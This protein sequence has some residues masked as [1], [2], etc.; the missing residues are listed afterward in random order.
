MK[1]NASVS[2]N[3]TN[4]K[5]APSEVKTAS[6]ATPSSKIVST[7]KAATSP[8][9]KEHS[10]TR[11]SIAPS[12]LSNNSTD[13][14]DETTKNK[15]NLNRRDVVL[16]LTAKD[17]KLD[18]STLE[19]ISEKNNQ[20]PI[21][22]KKGEDF[23]IWGRFK[24]EWKITSLEKNDYKNLKALPFS[25]QNTPKLIKQNDELLTT[26]VYKT[27]SKG[28]SFI[29]L[30]IPDELSL[31][32]LVGAY[33]KITG[34]I[35]ETKDAVANTTIKEKWQSNIA[36]MKKYS[37]SL[38]EFSQ[39]MS[40]SDNSSTP[41]GC[42]LVLL[43]L[44]EEKKPYSPETLTAEAKKLAQKYPETPILLKSNNQFYIYGCLNNEWQLTQLTTGKNKD[45]EKLFFTNKDKPQLILKN[46][47]GITPVVVGI[48][49]KGHARP[50]TLPKEFFDQLTLIIQLVELLSESGEATEATPLNILYEIL[51]KIP[52]LITAFDA[53]GLHKTVAELFDRLS[54]KKAENPLVPDAVRTMINSLFPNSFEQSIHEFLE[55]LLKYS[56]GYE[57]LEI[58]QQQPI[59][60]MD[61]QTDTLYIKLGT[62]SFT[63]YIAPDK[64][65]DKTNTIKSGIISSKDLNIPNPPTLE[66]LKSLL[67]NI[68]EIV[69]KNGHIKKFTQLPREAKAALI[70]TAAQAN[71]TLLAI[72]LNY[73][74]LAFNFSLK[75]DHLSEHAFKLR[76][77]QQGKETPKQNK[78][79]QEHG[80][81]L[82][83]TAEKIADILRTQ[84]N[85]CGY[86]HT[87]DYYP[88]S[89]SIL[90]QRKEMLASLAKEKKDIDTNYNDEIVKA[91]KI[92]IS[93]LKKYA[94]N[95][96]KK[97]LIEQLIDQLELFKKPS[98]NCLT[99]AIA[100][101][102]SR[103]IDTS[104]L[105]SSKIKPLFDKFNTQ[106]NS[107]ATC[108]KQKLTILRDKEIQLTKRVNEAQETV[109]AENNNNPMSLPPTSS[110]M[111]AVELGKTLF[112]QA[113]IIKEQVEKL[114]KKLT[115][116]KSKSFDIFLIKTSSIFIGHDNK[117]HLYR[118][119]QPYAVENSETPVLINQ[120]GKLSWYGYLN[121]QWQLIAI[122][123][124]INEL[125]TLF[126]DCKENILIE[127]NHTTLS[128]EVT[129]ILT[130][131]HAPKTSSIREKVL[132]L[133]NHLK[134]ILDPT[135]YQQYF[136]GKNQPTMDNK[137]PAEIK[138][139]T[140]VA[141]NNTPTSSTTSTSNL[142]LKHT[143]T[144]TSTQSNNTPGSL[145]INPNENKLDTKANTTS[146]TNNSTTPPSLPWIAQVGISITSIK[147]SILVLAAKQSLPAREQTPIRDIQKT[148]ESSSEILEQLNTTIDAYEQLEKRRFITQFSSA[149]NIKNYLEKTLDSVLAQAKKL[150]TSINI[151]DNILKKEVKLSEKLIAA[152]TELHE[153]YPQGSNATT[154]FSKV[155]VAAETIFKKKQELNPDY[156]TPDNNAG[157]GWFILRNMNIAELLQSI[158]PIVNELPFLAKDVY[159]HMLQE[160][161]LFMRAIFLF[162]D[163]LES[164]FYLKEGVISQ[165]KLFNNQSLFDLAQLV[166]TKIET[167]G[168]EFT[169]VERFPYLEKMSAQRAL[170]VE[171]ET[172]EVKK[173][174]LN[175]RY[176]SAKQ[177]LL[178]KNNAPKNTDSSAP[179]TSTIKTRIETLNDELSKCKLSTYRKT[180]KHYFLTQLQP[181][182]ANTTQLDNALDQLALHSDDS[183]PATQEGAKNMNAIME[184]VDIHTRVATNIHLLYEGR[185]GE[186]IKRLQYHAATRDTLLT[187][188]D[189]TIETLKQQRENFHVFAKS[190]R[191]LEDKV[192]AF[193]QLRH[194]LIKSGY[195]LKDALDELKHRNISAYK[196]LFTEENNL[197]AEFKK[198]DKHISDVTRGRKIIDTLSSPAPKNKVENNNTY[199]SNQIDTRIDELNNSCFK[200]QIKAEKIRLLT[201]LKTLVA[202]NVPLESAL[203]QLKNQP[204]NSAGFYL[205]FEGKTGKVVKDIQYSKLSTTD[206]LHRIDIEISRL[207][208]QRTE[209]L[210]F[211]VEQR[212]Y[213]LEKRIQ[214]LLMLKKTL[215]DF[216]PIKNV[217]AITVLLNNMH[218][219]HRNVLNEYESQLLGDL[220]QWD[221]ANKK[222]AP[223]T[224]VVFGL[225]DSFSAAIKPKAIQPLEI[226]APKP[227][228][229]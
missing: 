130:K 204:E 148:V 212:K 133:E 126:A 114:H 62:D 159:L 81:Y 125:L 196:L 163:K 210:Y 136:S 100:N 147:N 57:L 203:L 215:A 181:L 223:L 70:T 31:A 150:K 201:A 158:T 72:F 69:A 2:T 11:A 110:Q 10:T 173:G 28:H 161:N 180:E 12:V 202:D 188:V 216:D 132:S 55:Q 107:A 219:R 160:I 155:I 151:A 227:T 94:K 211:F 80:I 52:K 48:I 43:K 176:E 82:G 35:K 198:I 143:I 25:N 74:K 95:S 26:E 119:G 199:A 23:F 50:N 156:L 209:K 33:S 218:D 213:T 115:G 122:E 7:A 228:A 145:I 19:E 206:I 105:N 169:P 99:V 190:R 63:Y 117:L 129:N 68:L 139:P 187:K 78:E 21:I 22:I 89:K 83:K 1:T 111:P 193:I 154:H 200:S 120:N 92:L 64:N 73:D 192:Y 140:A 166:H 224:K 220:Q 84:T 44:E 185:T 222:A 39:E 24:N 16:L 34:R 79:Y 112:K 118:E 165:L 77:N 189:G 90:A 98:A 86:V 102:N 194:L 177:K 208:E 146:C 172:D 103:G 93:D 113:K 127:K 15:K 191:A 18:E 131:Y 37:A 171:K 66:K 32:N 141:Q 128:P 51:N 38:K 14:D 152:Q 101:L 135:I 46:D 179:I 76:L 88:Y 65:K 142:D 137:N 134:D 56:Q 226:E 168:Y 144:P 91:K 217:D 20:A 6:A 229:P 225:F 178:Q 221:F 157:L 5:I 186:M 53:M 164:E 121:N 61:L 149:D 45:L 3:T 183:A 109:A 184:K 85:E 170:L 104:K 205:L 60:Q 195:T 13:S 36:A 123:N 41:E 75:K 116:D 40:D 8:S 214:A 9:A 97:P 58:I 71:A 182:L 207:R 138:T 49:R 42:N 59:E 67:P 162:F 174:F 197:L 124:N 27:L 4:S 175:Q 54:D 87:Q 17:Q 29:T 30:I 47:T 108:Q 153:K 96:E 167:M 106:L